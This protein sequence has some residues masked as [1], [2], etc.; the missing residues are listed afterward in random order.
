MAISIR[1]NINTMVVKLPI[2]I[3]LKKDDTRHETCVVRAMD[4]N[5][6]EVVSEK[7]LRNNGAKMVTALLAR[8]IIKVGEHDFPN[9]VGENV[10]REMFSDDRDTCLVAVRKLMRD[11]MEID[12]R[13]PQCGETEERVIYMSKKLAE[14][15]HWGDEEIHQ[16]T[17]EVG[18]IEFEL[19][20]GLVVFDDSDNSE[21]ICKKGKIQMPTGKME[22]LVAKN[23]MKNPGSA[24]SVLLSSCI[25][26]IENIRRV[27]EDVVKAMSRNDREYL[28]SLVE[29]AKCGPNFLEEIECYSCDYE[30]KFMMQLPY[31]FTSGRSRK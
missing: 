6:E 22:E 17:N 23:G 20:D 12:A 30:Y 18:V 24:N 4:G 28:S 7:K 13:C 31:F 11:E 25:R 29:D 2:G 27:D 10:V 5:D 26:E 16:T 15:K 21:K 9:G 19:P 14:C 8:K 1:A 3:Y